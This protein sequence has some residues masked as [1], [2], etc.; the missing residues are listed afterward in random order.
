[1]PGT[2]PNQTAT[3]QPAFTYKHRRTHPHTGTHLHQRHPNTTLNPSIHTQHIHTHT[4]NHANTHT[5][6]RMHTHT[7]KHTQNHTDT[8][9]YATHLHQPPNSSI[10]IFTNLNT[11]LHYCMHQNARHCH[12]TQ[13]IVKLI[14][15]NE[16]Y[17]IFMQILCI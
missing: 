17:L 9:T 7:H 4:Q 13:L 11:P 8:Q 12:T 3:L 1:M 15:K 10:H 6:P 2:Y 5:Q 14:D 16:K